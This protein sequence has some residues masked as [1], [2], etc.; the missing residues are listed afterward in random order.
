ME[1]LIISFFKSATTRSAALRASRAAFLPAAL[2]FSTWRLAVARA[3]KATTTNVIITK[4]ARTMTMAA[5]LS[6]WSNCRATASV[7]R[8]GESLAGRVFSPA[9]GALALQ[10]SGF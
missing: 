4:K 1:A 9:S 7:A 5:P 3:K 2:L 8:D 6:L 10:F